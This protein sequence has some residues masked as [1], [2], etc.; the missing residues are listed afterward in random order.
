VA[1]R[2]SV[3]VPY[4]DVA[5]YIGDCLES[6]RRQTFED[7]EIVLV[8]D[9]SR[10]E[11]SQIAARYC[12]QDSRFRIVAQDNQGLG[13][14]RNTGAKYC[15]G[16]YITFVDSDDVVPRR[17]FEAMVGS[18]D[19]TGSS[20]AAGGARRFDGTLVWDSWQ[21]RIPFAAD[22]PATHVLEFP[23]LVLDRMVWN[24]VFRRSFWEE[25]GYT[26]PAI[27]YEDYPVTLRAHFEA[28]TV[29]CISAPI[30]YWR[31]RA[32]RSSI[33]QRKYEYPNLCD[34]VASA[35]MVLDLVDQRPADL[36][37]TVYQ[38]FAQVDI[39]ALV[40]AFL[41]VPDPDVAALTR[42]G[43]R[44]AERLDKRVIAKLAPFDRLQHHA[45][46][47]GDADLLRR[48][49]GFRLA[50]G[51]RG[52]A[53]VRRHP[54]LP[55]RFEAP[56]PGLHDRP[57]SVPR[58]LYQLPRNPMFIYTTVSD[59]AWRDADLIVR[60]TAE[61]RQNRMD[62]R[63][64]MRVS[65][66]R[67]GTDIPLAFERFETVD[68]HGERNPVGYEA[69]MPRSLLARLESAQ[70]PAYLAVDINHGPVHRRGVVRHLRPGSPSAA[71][72]GWVSERGWLQPGPG[73]DGRLILEHVTDPCRLTTASVRDGAVVLT[74][75]LPADAGSVLRLVRTW[76][77]EEIADCRVTEDGDRREFL[78]RIPLAGLADP[79]DP[80]DP[81]SGRTIRRVQVAGGSGKH[82][83]LATGLD[84]TVGVVH[85]ERL[86]L[87]SRSE[88]GVVQIEDGPARL[89]AD[90]AD[91]P[92][93]TSGH[94]LRIGGRLWGHANDVAL[95]WRQ[96]GVDTTDA[97]V[98]CVL[99]ADDDR[100]SATVDLRSLVPRPAGRLADVPASPIGWRLFARPSQGPGYVVESDTY[101]VSRPTITIDVGEREYGLRPYADRLHLEVR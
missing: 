10:D 17:A 11:S 28:L 98:P 67:D 41:S 99:V 95:V 60:G 45:L 63:T 100:W 20:F 84:R 79:S 44:F 27:R 32:S 93:A 43:R 49:A 26:F 101:L 81:V 8:D 38:H 37:A 16:E 4:Y 89:I 57:R 52:V 64:R 91:G 78:A 7:L 24:K 83:L 74:G 23:P 55:W 15:E 73:P 47:T 70:E 80:D 36:R 53:R 59:I 33:T 54:V 42:L 14:A 34:R 77:T 62:E 86:I 69:R 56:Y 40:E 61:I 18:L 30:Y 90:E 88:E 9:G 3:V 97:D 71:P 39:V 35:E 21:H 96:V 48:L 76:Y 66:V 65:L 94:P 5:N 22:R 46:R 51:L 6:L 68:S 75:L 1:P 25:F 13:P 12:N 92:P 19:E 50:G 58:R 82:D 87:V 31:E 29:D 2:L 72:G 85:D